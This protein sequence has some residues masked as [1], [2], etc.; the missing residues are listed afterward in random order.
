MYYVYD[1]FFCNFITAAARPAGWDDEM[2]KKNENSNRRR[3][4]GRSVSLKRSDYDRAAAI[5]IINR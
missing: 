1:F 2:K 3:V 4:H 5:I